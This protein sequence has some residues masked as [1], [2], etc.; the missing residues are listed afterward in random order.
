MLLNPKRA[1]LRSLLS[2]TEAEKGE[3]LKCLD[4]LKCSCSWCETESFFSQTAELITFQLLQSKKSKTLKLHISQTSCSLRF[5]LK[6]GVPQ[7]C[8]CNTGAAATCLVIYRIK[9]AE[10]SACGGNL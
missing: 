6:E 4:G 1:S 3:R 5:I 7:S 9:D 2:T 10:K 8:I